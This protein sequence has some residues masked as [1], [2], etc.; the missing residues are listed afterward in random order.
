MS[1]YLPLY[2]FL[3]KKASLQMIVHPYRYTMLFFLVL[4]WSWQRHKH[5]SL[6]PQQNVEEHVRFLSR[7]LSLIAW[8]L[9]G[10]H[11]PALNKKGKSQ[12]KKEIHIIMIENRRTSRSL[13]LYTLF[14]FLFLISNGLLNKTRWNR[15][16]KHRYTRS[17]YLFIIYLFIQVSYVLSDFCI[18]LSF[19][20]NQSCSAINYQCR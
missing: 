8:S 1:G 2:F 20:P 11:E 3:S 7:Q 14:F 9:T 13:V 5:P 19:T 6:I 18:S 16:G 15:I 17:P 12:K 4:P 10:P